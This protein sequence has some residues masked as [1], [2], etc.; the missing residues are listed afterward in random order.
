M[1]WQTPKAILYLVTTQRQS[2][3]TCC[4]VQHHST[5]DQW[6]GGRGLARC[7][8]A[9]M[10]TMYTNNTSIFKNKGKANGLSSH[11]RRIAPVRG[12]F[13]QSHFMS[14]PAAHE[15]WCLPRTAPKQAMN[16]FKSKVAL[17]FC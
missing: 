15:A 7:S 6:P 9:K 12:G 8:N 11:L 1:Q 17:S 2:M 4:H 10:N 14:F 16:I 3:L 13:E 5:C